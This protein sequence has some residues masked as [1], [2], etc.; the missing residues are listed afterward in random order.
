MYSIITLS[1]K[2]IPYCIHPPPP[3]KIA[4]DQIRLECLSNAL[5]WHLPS[6]ESPRPP[7]SSGRYVWYDAV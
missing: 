2:Y 7:H 6:T 1:T 3:Q 5:D 4:L